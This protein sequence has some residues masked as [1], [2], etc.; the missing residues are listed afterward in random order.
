MT[1]ARAIFRPHMLQVNTMS[2]R[3][4]LTV[5]LIAGAAQ[6]A[7][8]RQISCRQPTALIQILLRYVPSTERR[9]QRFLSHHALVVAR[10]HRAAGRLHA[11]RRSVYR[12]MRDLLAAHLQFF[13]GARL[14]RWDAREI[15]KRFLAGLIAQRRSAH[16]GV[17][18]VPMR[19]YI[20]EALKQFLAAE[21]ARRN[22]WSRNSVL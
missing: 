8:G 21:A 3:Q 18:R 5:L 13:R 12:E 22:A 16:P 7:S 2:A 17:A 1:L 6:A 14:R 15:A 19:I 20:R 9:S 10:R 4:G 11:S